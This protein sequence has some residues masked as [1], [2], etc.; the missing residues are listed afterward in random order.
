LSEHVFYK[1]DTTV[2]PEIRGFATK[3]DHPAHRVRQ[4]ERDL[5]VCEISFLQTGTL[6][7]ISKSGER[8]L[9][10]GCI[11][12]FA[13]NH[14][15]KFLSDSPHLH[16]YTVSLTLATPA[17]VI[18]PSDF[19]ADALLPGEAVLPGLIADEAFCRQLSPMIRRL[20]LVCEEPA[21]QNHLQAYALLFELLSKLT[22]YAIT[23]TKASSQPLQ[24]DVEHCQSACRYIEEH[25][26]KKISMKEVAEHI[27]ISYCYLCRLFPKVMG[28]NMTEY[29]NREKISRAQTLM[30]SRS[31]TVEQAGTA[32]GI[33]D[34]KYF[35][36]LFR[37]YTGMTT[38]EFK[39]MQ[40][41]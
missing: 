34:P 15:R 32:V 28:M 8:M 14:R 27:G 5:T 18:D 33:D 30:A 21:K 29:V 19:S 3:A 17:I 22:N 6:T 12:A 1:I 37:Q 7:E 38:S 13:R 41:R 25:L 23:A 24:R 9:K 36:R 2:L 40:K 10:D 11:N 26:S 35:T 31:L 20:A 4:S 16:E 39:R